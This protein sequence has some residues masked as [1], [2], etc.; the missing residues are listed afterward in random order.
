M[1]R[2]TIFFALALIFATAVGAGAYWLGWEAGR[3]APGAA[4]T[5]TPQDAATP[6]QERKDLYWHDPMYPQHK[7]DK[8]GK[9]PFMDMQLVPVFANE[10]TNGDGITVSSRV[11]QNLGVRI[12]PVEVGSFSRRIES[13]GTVA[14]DEHRIEV[15]ES[16]AAGWVERLQVRAENDPVK[17]SQL[18]AEVYSPDILAAQEEFL[19]ALRHVRAHPA[20]ARLAAATRARLSLLGL[21]DRQIHDL[22]TSGRAHRRI[23]L[24]SPLSGIVAK[25]G[26]REGMQVAPGAV[27]FS[28]VDLSTVWVSAE[29]VENQG[30]WVGEGKPVEARIAALP[31]KV[32]TGRVEYI[33]P[34]VMRET[35]TLTARIALKN[36]KLELK[37]GMFAE[38]TLHG[39][40]K[41][42]ALR[43]PSEAVIHTGSRSLVILAEGEG[44]FRPVEVETGMEAEGKTEILRGLEKGQQVVASGQ[45]LIDSEASL[46]SALDRLSEPEAAK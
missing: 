24:Y 25:L 8:P 41:T 2:R 14:F 45:F 43:V 34:Q 4:E 9:S 39:E 44:R 18:L 20:D 16:R 7:F 12:A 40:E 35:R 10:A 33:Y 46:R 42:N 1:E 13:V 29:I 31:G 17:R 6:R 5:L 3:A 28:V 38:L 32:F 23:G 22:E 26:V 15:V 36:P 19:L 37:P 27:M 30:A 21:S 11:T